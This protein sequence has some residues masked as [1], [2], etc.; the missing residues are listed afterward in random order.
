MDRLLSM[1]AFQQVVDDG[2]FAAAARTLDM[3]PAVMT[4]LITDLEQHLGARLL[5]RTTRKLS[6]TEAGQS[7]LQRVRHILNDVDQAEASTR[8]Q[9]DELAGLLRIHT[10]PVMAVHI[11]APLVAEFR[12]RYP[13]VVLDI[14]VDSPLVPPIED[15]DLTI[16]GAGRLYDANVVARPVIVSEGLLCASPRYLRSSGT[17]R[18]PDDLKNHALLRLSQAGIRQREWQ[19]INPE[20]GDREV[21]VE[22]KPVMMANHSDT[23]L[24]ATLDGTGISAQPLDLVANYL[25]DGQLRRVLAPWITGRFTLYAALP[26]RKYVP[27]RARV[28]MEFLIEQTRLKAAEA[29]RTWPSR[30]ED[31]AGDPAA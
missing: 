1:R 2:G 29:E 22:V 4:R 11:I 10:Q 14:T 17:P 8:Q 3:S 28:F 15:Y 25:R 5:Q 27:A 9:T 30:D 19:L 26:S 23:L 21:A 16:L 20:E 31:K 13:K 7:Y 6:L 24:R 18:Q 12:R